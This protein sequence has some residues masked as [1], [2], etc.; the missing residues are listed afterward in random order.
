MA[1]LIVVLALSEAAV[2]VRASWEWVDVEGTKCM[3]GEQTGIWV[4]EGSQR[5][6]LGIYLYGGG[7]C[8]NAITCD[9]ASTTDPK[10]SD[11][12]SS[13]IFESSADNPL[14]DFNWIAVPYCTGDVHAGENEATIGG[15][16]RIFNG[17][18]NLKL[19]MA[20][21]TSVFKDVETLLVTGES[22]GGFGALASYATIRDYFPSARGVMLDDS[23]P[24][25]DDE[26]IPVCLQQEWRTSWG[27]NN[28]LP[29]DCLC[30]NDGGNL[31]STWDYLKQTYPQDSFG[32]VS[33]VTDSVI[34]LF[35][36]F[37]LQNC[38]AILPIGYTAIHAG[39]ERLASNGTS[40]YMI[41]GSGHTHTSHDEFNTRTVEGVVLRDWIGQLVDGAQA[42]P[43]TVRPTAEDLYA[44]SL[45]EAAS[46]ANNNSYL[47]NLRRYSA[48]SAAS[49]WATGAAVTV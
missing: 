2:D 27:M 12:G 17:A 9:L 41:P 31:V 10:P 30:N 40:I 29:A 24:I 36:V 18:V 38:H 20:H 15:A 4:R 1:K 7:A 16:Q 5:K 19:D 25:M 32:L 6:N 45:E 46:T 3:S 23:G 13:G 42:D 8:F 43:D 33:S 14:A 28:N 37:S 21:A 47:D 44:E 22:A 49:D 26:A 34:S 11:P 39:L 35:F 48:G